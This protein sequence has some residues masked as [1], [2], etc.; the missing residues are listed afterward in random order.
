MRTTPT[1]A[2]E[3]LLGLTPL[4]VL[5]EAEAGIYRLMCSHQWKPKSTNFCPARKSKNDTEIC[6]P[7]AIHGQI[8]WEV[9]VEEWV[10]NQVLKRTWSGIQT[11]PR[12]IKALVLG[13]IDEAPEGAQIQ[14]GLHMTVFQTKIYIFLAW[15]KDNIGTGYTRRNI[16]ILNDSPAAIMALDSFQI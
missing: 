1:A 8:P 12:P 13:C 16:Y 7:Q 10:Q 5:T 11:G 2:T 14:P 3:V 4:H 15:G 9:W 6:I